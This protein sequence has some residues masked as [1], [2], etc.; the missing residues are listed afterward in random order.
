[1]KKNYIQPTILA[2]VLQH[3]Q[4]IAVISRIDGDGDINPTPEPGDGSGDSN[5]RV[6]SYNIWDDEW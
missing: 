2:V 4:I 6:K 1:M 3:S 5:P